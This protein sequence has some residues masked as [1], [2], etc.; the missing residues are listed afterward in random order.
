MNIYAI[1]TDPEREDTNFIPMRKGFS[2]IAAILN[3]FWALYHKMWSVVF[4]LLM[5][6]MLVFVLQINNTATGAIPVIHFA[7]MAIFGFFTT[8]LRE[9][10]LQKKGYHLED[11][12][13]AP[14]E[15]EAE[16][17]FITRQNF[18]P[19]NTN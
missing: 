5:I 11:I 8:E 13:L 19:N 18:N 4:I 1:Y 7:T 10:Y 6:N 3:F 15:L 14:S 17:K 2:F 12:V 9:Y 16:V